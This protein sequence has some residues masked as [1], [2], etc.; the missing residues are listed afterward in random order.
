MREHKRS[1]TLK[2]VV[3]LISCDILSDDFSKLDKKNEKIAI[4]MKTVLK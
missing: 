4:F 2:K 3:G 1:Q